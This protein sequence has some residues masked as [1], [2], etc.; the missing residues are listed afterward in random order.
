MTRAV[1]APL[2]LRLAASAAAAARRRRAGRRRGL[3]AICGARR[4]RAACATRTALAPLAAFA[5]RTRR[6]R[7]ALLGRTARAATPRSSRVRPALPRRSPQASPRQAGFGHGAFRRDRRDAAA[8]GVS[9]QPRRQRSARPARRLGSGTASAIGAHP[10]STGVSGASPAHR[11][12]VGWSS[13]RCERFGRRLPS[14][15][16]PV[17]PQAAA[18]A[19]F[20][21]FSMR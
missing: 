6:T 17:R 7:P 19:G 4:L 3:R 8:T 11:R 18:S 21:R 9:A 15:L 5:L 2:G 10:A 12:G 13:L 14:Q 20:A 16:P 1:V